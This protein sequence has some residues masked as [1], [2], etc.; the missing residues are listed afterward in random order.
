MAHITVNVEFSYSSVL[1]QKEPA[2]LSFSK[3]R[4]PIATLHPR[5][6]RAEGMQYFVWL[7]MNSNSMFWNHVSKNITGMIPTSESSTAAKSAE[8]YVCID[9]HGTLVRYETESL[10]FQRRLQF[11]NRK[12]QYIFPSKKIPI[13]IPQKH[14]ARFNQQQSRARKCKENSAT[15]NCK[16]V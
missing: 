12:F 7:E 15:K 1:K 4:S 9:H 14:R 13:Y 2:Q 8:L 16:E 10:E 6:P 5:G 3:W 11:G